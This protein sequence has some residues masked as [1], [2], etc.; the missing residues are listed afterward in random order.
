LL[1]TARRLAGCFVWA[2]GGSGAGV[3]LQV[4]LP[5]QGFADITPLA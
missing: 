5:V 4:K 1:R 3:L 2:A